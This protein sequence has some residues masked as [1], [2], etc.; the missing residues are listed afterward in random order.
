MPTCRFTGT[1][2]TRQAE[3]LVLECGSLVAYLCSVEL[4]KI[5][6]GRHAQIGGYDR[7]RRR[8][9]VWHGLADFNNTIS[10]E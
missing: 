2:A 8:S 7:D 3:R 10:A 9:A 4:S 6:A 5:P 1:L